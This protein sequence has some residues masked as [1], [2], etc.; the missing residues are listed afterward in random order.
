MSAATPPAEFRLKSY[1]FRREREAGW[2]ELEELVRRVEKRGLTRLSAEEL[3][4][5]PTLYRGVL[6]SLSVAR[7]ISLDK[8]VITYLE[9]LSA[10]AYF[11][12]YCRKRELTATVWTFIAK[13]FPASVRRIRWALFLAIG[14]TALGAIAGHV[15]V[16][17]DPDRYFS[18]VPEEMAQGRTPESSKEEL[19]KILTDEGGSGSELARFASFLFTHNA[20]IGLLCFALGFVAGVPV[21][22]LLFINGAIL[23]AMWALYAAKDLGFEF[24]AWVFPHGVTEFLAIILCGAAGLSVGYGLIFPGR[25]RRLDNLAIRGRHAAAIAVGAV[26][27]F[28]IA[29]LFEGF[30]RQIVTDTDTRLV[31]IALTATLW[32]L[33]FGFAGRGG[34]VSV[35]AIDEP[36]LL[37]GGALPP[38]DVPAAVR[39]RA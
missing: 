29:A 38:P 2:K 39:G 25:F 23:G 5:L 6:S 13:T 19:A 37:L 20:K 9:G 12:I 21:M 35:H 34:P 11:A 10:R 8:N 36:D 31:V 24:F 7:A 1:E 30:F 14:L 4:R 33:Y 32:S 3:Q 28:F 17:N 18:F 16:S 27:M 22:L 15:L 26:G